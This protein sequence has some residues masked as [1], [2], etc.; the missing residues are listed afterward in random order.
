MGMKSFF[1]ALLLLLLALLLNGCSERVELHRQLSEQ[2]ANE[3][4]AELAD[5]HICPTR[6]D[7]PGARQRESRTTR[8]P[9]R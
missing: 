2:E 7:F 1:P 4:I 8:R 9:I 3:V 5:K 6:S